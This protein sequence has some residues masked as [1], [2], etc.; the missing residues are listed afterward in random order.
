M[1]YF[2]GAGIKVAI[3]TSLAIMVPTVISGSLTHYFNQNVE[4]KTA[5][6]M[7][8]GAIIG[9]YLGANLAE[10]LSEVLLKRLFALILIVAAVKMFTE[11][12]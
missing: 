10:I 12:V 8:L 3:G 6:L 5:L 11:T 2:L 1:V 9:A 4:W 7:A